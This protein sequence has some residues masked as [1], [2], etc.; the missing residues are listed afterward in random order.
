MVGASNTT[1]EVH[2][3]FLS[4]SGLKNKHLKFNYLP[5]KIVSQT[6]NSEYGNAINI[7]RESSD[8]RCEGF[9]AYPDHKG[10]NFCALGTIAHKAGENPLRIMLGLHN[11]ERMW[12]K[13]GVNRKEMKQQHKACPKC[14]A[15]TTSLRLIAHLNDIHR[16]QWG[17]I[18]DNLEIARSYDESKSNII[19]TID[20]LKDI[21]GYDS[22]LSIKLFSFLESKF[23]K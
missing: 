23:N 17:E 16:L 22:K 20:T 15:R 2:M 14:G 3:H 18:A 10:W 21:I 1:S 12:S 5:Y 7:L 6:I 4:V 13:M 9:Y 19:K 8:R 11:K